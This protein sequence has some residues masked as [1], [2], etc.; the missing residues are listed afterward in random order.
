MFAQ[1][2]RWAIWNIQQHPYKHG[3]AEFAF[4]S[5]ALPGVTNAEQAL[6]F[7]IAVLYPNAKPAVADPASLP[8]VG[9]TIN[10]YRVVLD[11]G[12]GNFAAYR[13]EQREGDVAP[14]WYKVMD[15]DW[16]SDSI[17]AQ[18]LDVTL[19]LYVSKNGITDIDENG[20]PIVGLYAGQKIYGGDAAN[21]N[22]TLNANSGDG[23]G[24]QT[25]YVQIDSQFRPT[26]HNTYD[27]GTNTERWRTG[28]FATSV[29]SGTL[30]LA[31]GS[32]TDTS[33]NISFGDENLTTTGNITGAIVTGT[34]LVADDTVNQLTIVPGSITDTS[35]AIDF[36]DENL[37]TTG[38]LEAAVTTLTSTGV[39]YNLVSVDTN[40]S[41]GSGVYV[42]NS[43]SL[44]FTNNFTAAIWFKTT[45]HGGGSPGTIFGSFEQGGFFRWFLQINAGLLRYRVTA[46]GTTLGKD[47][48]SVASV[49]D[50]SWHQAVMTFNT[51]VL[52]CYLDGTELTFGAG[53]LTLD[54]DNVVNALF[55]NSQDLG[56]GGRTSGGGIAVA[57]QGNVDEPVLFNTAL[58]P[59]EVT[60]LWNG[61]FAYNLTTHSQAGSII[62]YW[63]AGD[64]DIGLT[65]TDVVGSNN[66]TL[67]G[68][69]SF[70]TVDYAPSAGGASETLVLNPGLGTITSSL[71]TI[72]F[73]NENLITTG[74]IT[75]GSLVAGDL[76]IDNLLLDNNR[77]SITNLN[78]NLELQANGTGVVNV[79]SPMTTIG[80]TVTG[81]VDIT[82]QLNVDQLVLNANTIS[83]VTNNDINLD[84]HGSGEVV[85]HDR[86]RPVSDNNIDIG[87]SA[88][89]VRTGYIG[90]SLHNGVN[91]F[92][93]GELMGLRSANYRDAARTQAVQPG[94]ALFWSGSQWLASAPDTEIDH[95]T[96]S[97]LLDDDH[98]QY[99]LLAGRA[100]GQTLL[101]GVNASDNLTLGSTANATKGLV[102]TQDDF[103]PVTN[104]NFAVTWQGT[105]LGGASNY[106]RDL[107]TKGELRGARMENFTSGAL[108][109]ASAQ[110]IGR[111]VFATDNN[112]AYVDIGGS[113]QVLGVSKYLADTVWNGTDTIKDVNVSANIQDAREAI[114]ALHDNA[115]NFERIYT[116]ISAISATTVRITVS[117]ALPAGSYRL[118]GIE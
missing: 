75:A 80:Q 45:N 7:M 111:Y 30:T 25:G 39:G 86:I 58:T 6:N 15:M 105:D 37:S 64:G 65:V 5:P 79:L 60:E 2:H 23:V 21:Q 24:A 95:G 42:P 81:T 8:L 72:D 68:A 56:I 99:M 63:R 74:T 85:Y 35:G 48:G 92:L 31:S 44:D 13:W 88:L 104:A 109:A 11:D 20:D 38:T 113:W 70:D 102:L 47:Y 98:T 17:L 87:T 43:A 66:G 116:N 107:Y 115:N 27:T 97:G 32:I 78:G 36:G 94:D 67:S 90:T 84:P 61:G 51:N 83:T 96:V 22:L 46:D 103:A 57:M 34:S 100:G 52:R 77:V 53:T 14:Q 12:D 71:G 9:N 101:G 54:A 73:D 29:V 26:L 82:G 28:Y 41:S 10:D 69:A 49:N 114:W 118:I 76:A 112:K 110:N 18:L 4:S 59:A 19:P 117:P 3:L 93:M 62:S 50:G 40:P 108:P 91:E 106:F 1:H 16:S 89:K 55:S 33:G